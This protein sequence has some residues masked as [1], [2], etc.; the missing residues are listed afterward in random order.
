MA[1]CEFF[2]KSESLFLTSSQES[3]VRRKKMVEN[4]TI[5]A[6]FLVN[7]DNVSRVGVAGSLSRGKARPS[8]VDLIVFIDND[9]AKKCQGE[10]NR[11]I[12][13]SLEDDMRLNQYLGM[14]DNKWNL[15]VSLYGMLCNVKKCPIDVIIISDSP[16]NEYKQMMIDGNTDPDFLKNILKDVLIYDSQMNGF[17]KIM[18]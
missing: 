10:R 15:F 1:G 8:D 11:L 16:D 3:L 2:N 4:A 18:E 6:S 13:E 12:R 5:L 17:G 9:N 14:D 7:C